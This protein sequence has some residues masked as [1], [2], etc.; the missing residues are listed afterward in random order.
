MGFGWQR[1]SSASTQA[2]NRFHQVQ[3]V[4]AGT[5]AWLRVDDD[6]LVRSEDLDPGSKRQVGSLFDQQA[7]VDLG[8]GVQ[9]LGERYYRTGALKALPHFVGFI[10]GA[11][12]A[13]F[14]FLPI[15]E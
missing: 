8:G 15:G 13:I 4:R 11:T 6:P 1:L 14:L 9:L 5:H 3:F 7:L 12:L 2:T 10:V